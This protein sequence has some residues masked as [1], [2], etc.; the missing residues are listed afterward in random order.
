MASRFASLSFQAGALLDAVKQA[1]GHFSGQIFVNRRLDV[2]L[3]TDA[4]LHLPASGL[5]ATVARRELGPHRLLSAAVH[6]E[7]ELAR[8][9]AAGVDLA[10]VSPD[11]RNQQ[12]ANS[13]CARCASD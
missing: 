3:A 5:P 7:Q 8:A 12:Q 2:A 4:E 10:L 1:R 11:L 6:N 13:W 9:V